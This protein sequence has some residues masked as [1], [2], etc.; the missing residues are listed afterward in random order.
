MAEARAI[1]EAVT[2]ADTANAAMPKIKAIKHSLTSEKEVGVLFNA[3][4]KACG[5]FYD[6]VLKKYTP[7]PPEEEKKGSKGKAPAK[8]AKGAE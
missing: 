3:K 4:I 8:G 6:K 7:A 1:V 5:L 2:D